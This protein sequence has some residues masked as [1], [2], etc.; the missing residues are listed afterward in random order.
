MGLTYL[1]PLQVAAAMELITDQQAEE[2]QRHTRELHQHAQRT[3]RD[4]D[5][6]AYLAATSA[7]LHEHLTA[8]Q[9]AAIARPPRPN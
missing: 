2:L 5:A 3:G 9:W 1:H 6:R 8:E 7:W 4:E